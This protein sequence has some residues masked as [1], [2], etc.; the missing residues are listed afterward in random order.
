MAINQGNPMMVTITRPAAAEYAPYYSRYIDLVPQ[1]DIVDLLAGQIE[2]TL[3]LLARVDHEKAEYR[4]A[5]DKWSVKEVV[6]HV[7]DTER[8]FA[9]RAFAFSRND[10]NPLPGMEQEDYA[11]A[12]N[13][14]DRPLQDI[15]EEFREV[16]R[17]TISLCRSFDE[18]MLMRRGIASECEFSVRSLPYIIAGHELHHMR[19]LQDKYL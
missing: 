9:F 18:G 4:Y 3:S 11:R 8:V 2:K 1:G 16:R 17:S 14:H 7:V 19:V 13:Y 12:A 10:S 6:G 5:P 15:L